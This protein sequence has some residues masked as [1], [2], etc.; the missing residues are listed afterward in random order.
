MAFLETDG[1]FWFIFDLTIDSLFFL[2]VVINL[3]SS[4]YKVDGQLEVSHKKVVIKYAKS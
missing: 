3:M 4:Y 1:I 2:D